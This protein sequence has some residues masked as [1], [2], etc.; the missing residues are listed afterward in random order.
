MI[1]SKNLSRIPGRL[2]AESGVCACLAALVLAGPIFSSVSCS[3]TEDHAEPVIRPVITQVV[4]AP[5]AGRRRTFSGTAKAGLESALSFRVGGEIQALPVRVGT[6]VAE[7]DLIARLDPTDYE[8][9]VK[10]YEAQL[11]QTEAQYKQSRADY[12]RVRSLYE[13]GNVSK[14]ELDKAQAV[15]ESASALSDATRKN[16][17]LASQRLQHCTLKA[18]FAGAIASLPV[19]VH[20][21]VTSGETI[22]TLTSSDVMKFEIGM[23][24]AL[25]SEVKNGD[26]VLVQFETIPG[27]AFV[28]QVSE[29]GYLTSDSSTYPVKLK[30]LRS[31][32]R[33]RPGMVGEATFAFDISSEFVTVPP[34]AVVGAP[35]GTHY[36][37][38]YDP[39]GE[40]VV[41]R[42]VQIGSLTSSGLQITSGLSPNEI[43]VVRGAHRLEEGMRVRLLEEAERFQG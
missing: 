14:S 31:D 9:E 22:A 33:I 3:K 16:L 36:V 19:E 6:R 21:T 10:Q 18:P 7:G 11:A 26:T 20:Q 38:I 24:E 43:L 25:I 42:S 39:A 32:P 37:W 4:Q 35:D 28:A 15:F 12:R 41:K 29:V 13:A 1:T 8:L 2:K 5:P 27:E 40:R 17:E 23:P 30:L 34:V